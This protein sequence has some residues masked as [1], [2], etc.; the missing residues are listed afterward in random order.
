[1]WRISHA[2]S[3][4]YPW[5]L[6]SWAIVK[7]CETWLPQRK[8]ISSRVIIWDLESMP[9]GIIWLRLTIIA[10]ITSSR[11]YRTTRLHFVLNVVDLCQRCDMSLPACSNIRAP[12]FVIA[13][14]K[15]GL[16]KVTNICLTDNYFLIPKTVTKSGP[17]SSPGKATTMKRR[18]TSG[19]SPFSISFECV[20]ICGLWKKHKAK[21]YTL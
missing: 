10:T 21:R 20:L 12:D 14:P 19:S 3:S 16:C 15:I 4:C 8:H 7:V 9:Y 6:V 13:Y 17:G 1:M 11:N 5:C 2:G 18:W